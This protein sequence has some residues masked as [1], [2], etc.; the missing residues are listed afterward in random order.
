MARRYPQ[1][2]DELSDFRWVVPKHG[3]RWVTGRYVNSP[4]PDLP[5]H[6]E[7][8]FMVPEEVDGPFIR[9]KNYFPL[10]DEPGLF[11]IFATEVEPTEESVLHFANKYGGLGGKTESVIFL[12][13]N[14]L[15]ESKLSSGECL[16]AW[17][18]DLSRMRRLVALW[19]WIRKND[20]VA[21]SRHIRWR[22][23]NSVE[24]DSHPDDEFDSRDVPERIVI[25]STTDRPEVFEQFVRYD[26][27]EPAHW[28]LQ[29]AINRHLESEGVFA[30][31]LWDSKM[32]GLRLHIVPS[33]LSACLWLQFAQAVEGNKEYRQCVS[34]LRWMQVGG[35]K[36]SR[37]D[38]RHCSPTC[39]ARANRKKEEAVMK[40]PVDGGQLKKVAASKR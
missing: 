12:E 5:L 16:L 10:S 22:G 20:R 37:K 8:R 36:A 15:G 35:S 21:L 24:Y 18:A 19:D 25:A 14:E 7:D 11:K 26:C 23:D 28:H 9:R 2:P 34:C 31:L 6:P 27:V 30:R 39:R 4:H 33:S 32:S 29:S 3:F 17:R 38:K 1:T 13:S 40:S